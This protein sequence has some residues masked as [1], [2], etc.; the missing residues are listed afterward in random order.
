MSW[1]IMSHKQ[2][3]NCAASSGRHSQHR[4]HVVDGTLPVKR[5]SLTRSIDFYAYGPLGFGPR[6]DQS[7]ELA[8]PAFAIYLH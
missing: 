2:Y 5:H 7:A 1:A 8:H 3:R 4:N 6:A